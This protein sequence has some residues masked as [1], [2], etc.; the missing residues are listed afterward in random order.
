[1]SGY[2]TMKQVMKDEILKELGPRWPGTDPQEAAAILKVVAQFREQKEKTMENTTE[3]IYRC[4][5][6]SIELIEEAVH[7]YVHIFNNERYGVYLCAACQCDFWRTIGQM[8]EK[9][10]RGVRELPILGV[11]EKESGE[12]IASGTLKRILDKLETIEKELDDKVDKVDL[13]K[14]EP[15]HE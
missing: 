3:R 12:T 14:L 7:F 10:P 5:G 6:C 1:M 13:A 11:I 9:R 15:E 4:K 8:A 2:K